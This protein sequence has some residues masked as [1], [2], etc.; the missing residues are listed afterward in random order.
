MNRPNILPAVLSALT[1]ILSAGCS[2]ETRYQQLLDRVESPGAQLAVIEPDGA[3]WTGAA[4]EAAPGV[5][6]SDEHA[7][8]IGSNTKVFTA[9][10]VLQLVD[11]GLLELDARAAAWV[12]QLDPEITVRDLLQHTSGLGEYFEHETMTAD[13]RAALADLWTP[14]ELIDLGQEVRDDGP[15]ATAVYANTNFIAA[16][17]VVEAIEGRPFGEVLTDR[18][19]VPLGMDSSGFAQSGETVPAHLALGEGGTWGTVTWVDPSVGWAAGSVYAS[20]LDVAR[21]YD[22]ALSGE[23][24][25][26]ELVEAQLDVVEADLGFGGEDLETFYGLGIMVVEVGGQRIIGHRG[27]TQGATSL[28]IQDPETGAMAV[29]LTN[30][31]NVDILTIPMKTLRIAGRQ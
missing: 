7:F 12:P 13:N 25:G 17:L 9:A 24:Y 22:A 30:T 14:E 11:E 26:P 16:G 20:A 18:V 23:L 27:G 4:G 8:L 2:D 15:Q 31:S 10:V 5:A 1:L 21:F 3:L 19:F 28:A 6:V 29:L